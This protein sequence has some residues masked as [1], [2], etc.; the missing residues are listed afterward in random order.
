MTTLN[1]H[2]ISTLRRLYKTYAE[3]YDAVQH[4]I[5]CT[6]ANHKW[7]T[8]RQDVLHT[9]ATHDLIEPDNI[10]QSDVIAKLP[11]VLDDLNKAFQILLNH[12]KNVLRRQ[13]LPNLM[14]KIPWN[15][16]ETHFH[17]A[18]DDYIKCPFTS[19]AEMEELFEV[20]EQILFVS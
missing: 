5:T 18:L 19:L 12:P 17:V 7:L 16:H 6:N 20:M 1:H 10:S 11:V 15:C 3:D 2:Y 8:L 14:P 4:S 9:I 13:Y